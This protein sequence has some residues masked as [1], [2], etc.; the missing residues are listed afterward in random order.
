MGIH[1]IHYAY[2]FVQCTTT[3]TLCITASWS[4]DGAVF[5]VL[6]HLAMS[7]LL[8][9]PDPTAA[10]Y[11]FLGGRGP[12]P[13]KW[14]PFSQDPHTLPPHGSEELH[15][16]FQCNPIVYSM[17]EP[18]LLRFSLCIKISATRIFSQSDSPNKQWTA[19]AWDEEKG[20]GQTKRYAQMQ[21]GA[22]AYPVYLCISLALQFY[23]GYRFDF[24]VMCIIIYSGGQVTFI[25]KRSYF[26]SAT[27]KENYSYF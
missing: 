4:R 13:P 18:Q 26:T 11:P 17:C 16:V 10:H 19:F 14:R 25:K 5:C 24:S 27:G 22:G 9:C 15:Y 7:S 8:H 1:Y 6:S 20:L 3:L 2:S 12:L 23:R 21:R